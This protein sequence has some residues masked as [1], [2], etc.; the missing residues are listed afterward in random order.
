MKH[1]VSSNKWLAREID[2]RLVYRLVNDYNLSEILARIL[3]GRGINIEEVEDFINPKIRKALPDPFHL[4]DMEKACNR[5]YEAI[6]NNQKILIF[7]DYDVDGATSSALLKRLFT[8]LNVNCDIYIPDRIT[9]GYGPSAELM[10][11]FKSMD[12]SLVITVDCGVTAFD[13]LEY[14]DNI[15]LDVIVLDHHLSEILLPRAFAIVNPNRIDESSKYTNIAAVGVSFLFAVGLISTLKKNKYF[16]SSNDIPNLLDLLDLVALGTVCDMMPITGLNRAFIMQGLKVIARQ[17]NI[18]LKTLAQIACIEGKITTYHL[19]FVIGPRINAGGRVGSSYLGA[20]LLSMADPV[21]AY[22]YASRLESF[23]L[24]RKAIE[25]RIIEEA[26]II[27]QEQS[28]N[29]HIIVSSTS[30]HQ[31]VI[32]IVASKLKE[33]YQKPI[34]AISIENGIGK[35]SCRSVKGI[36]LGQKITKAKDMGLLIGGGGHAMAAGFTID[37]NK[38]PEFSL[39]L[40]QELSSDLDCFEENMIKYYDAFISPN[41]VNINLA[42]ELEKLEPYG[43]G[44]DEPL[45]LIEGLYVLKARILSNQHISILFAPSRDSYGTKAINGICFNGINSPMEQVLLS[46][47]VRKISIICNVK[48]NNWQGNNSLQVIV[49]DLIQQD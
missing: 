13:A 17:E 15:M 49:H 11:K 26:V 2:E 39:F 5:V 22:E 48:V 36:N 42:K 19:S 29:S 32:G 24:Q 28:G 18:G 16:T 14:A 47:K 4:I 46:E 7:G 44:N 25:T 10:S 9:E 34:I 30:W 27:A 8:M 45:I 6:I 21:K 12:Y 40:E 37:A 1:G 33:K 41:G 35:A 20:R 43:I 31:G 38:I 23:N 3:I